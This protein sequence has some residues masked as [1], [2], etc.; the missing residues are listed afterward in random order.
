MSRSFG[1]TSVTLRSLICTSPPEISSSPAIMRSSVDLPQPLGPT[2]T[3][4]SPSGIV[5]DTSL[6]TW[7]S[8][9][10]LRTLFNTTD[11]IVNPLS[12]DRAGHNPAIEMFLQT[13]IDDDAGQHRQQR[14]GDKNV[15]RDALI[16]TQRAEDHRNGIQAV[17]VDHNQRQQVLV[18]NHNKAEGHHRAERRF[19]QR[20]ND[21]E[22]NLPFVGAVNPRRLF[23][24]FRYR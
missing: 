18:S 14:N 9:Y 8:P 19:Y 20:Q 7:A 21:V 17:L 23:Q 22:E 10:D 13:Q 15:R 24:L 5:S 2:R 12:F 11:P 6:M 1:S 4:N 3:Q 16:G